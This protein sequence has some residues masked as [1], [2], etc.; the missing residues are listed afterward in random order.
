MSGFKPANA[1]HA[2]TSVEFLFEFDRQI[3]TDHLSAMVMNP[4]TL[5]SLPWYGQLPAASVLPPMLFK[6]Q[7]GALEPSESGIQFAYLMPNGSPVWSMKIVA[8]EIRIVCS[9]YTRWEKVWGYARNLMSQAHSYLKDKDKDA[10]LDRVT[11]QVTDKF[12]GGQSGYDARSLLRSGGLLGSV[13]FE[14]GDLWH[15][16]SGWFDKCDHGRILNNLNV[17]ATGVS[18][19][20]KQIEAEPF[21]ISLIHMQ[22]AILVH[23]VDENLLLVNDV[24]EILHENNKK[25]LRLILTDQQ[26]SDIGLAEQK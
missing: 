19:G 6:T 11:L 3:S 20:P 10:K 26:L 2:L 4:Q 23:P 18:P 9:Q 12:I 8:D 13:P 5:A 25:T 7:A 21:S 15:V 17:Q 14:S 1:D 16:F 24:M 22:R